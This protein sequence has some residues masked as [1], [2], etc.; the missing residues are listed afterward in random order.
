MTGNI[1]SGIPHFQPPPFSFNDTSTEPNKIYA[2]G[3]MISEL[4]ATTIII[5][6]L[7]ILN[8]VAIAKVFCK[9]FFKFL[10]YQLSCQITKAQ[11]ILF[12]LLLLFYGQNF[13]NGADG[14]RIL[15][16]FQSEFHSQKH[17][18]FV[19]NK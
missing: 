8:T 17:P 7:A 10:K 1:K 14:N 11:C 16:E 12:L 13:V 6:L 18:A 9:Y 2:F 5:P 3:D 4:G 15:Q 19:K